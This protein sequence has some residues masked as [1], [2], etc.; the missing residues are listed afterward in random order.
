[1]VLQGTEIALVLRPGEVVPAGR[2]I[3][4]GVSGHPG[5]GDAVERVRAVLDRGKDIVRFGNAQQVPWLVLRQ[6][7]VAPPHNRAQV[8]LLQGSANAVAVEV[9]GAEV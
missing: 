2:S 8:F 5:R 7:L 3:K 4:R 6:L 9:H 1:A